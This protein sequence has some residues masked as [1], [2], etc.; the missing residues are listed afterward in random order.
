MKDF[1]FQGSIWLG[2]R[3]ANG[4][5]DRL[6]QVGD[7]P[8]LQL[9]LTTDKSKRTESRSG[10]HVTSAT[11]Q[12]GKTAELSMTLNYF[13]GKQLALGLY[14][15][16]ITVEG[17]TV[18]SEPFPPN[19][20]VGDTI[21]LDHGQISELVITDATTGTP[22]TL[23]PDTDYRVES[24]NG[25]LITL[26]SLGTPAFQQPLAGAYKYAG[27]VDVAMFTAGIPER[28]LLLDGINT[29]DGADYG[30]PVLL[31][32]W[33]CSFD[34]IAQ[35]DFISDDF[36]QLQLSGDVLY[37]DINASNSELGGFGKIS[38]SSE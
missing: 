2:T 30:K 27:G 23:V 3:L 9:K 36:G 4:K 26:S 32:L 18:T 20:K 11:L 25:G 37:D 6:E 17:G 28:Y 15:T 29:V 34:P 22:K 14:G 31:R 24:A 35:V 7:A 5:P 12:K 10:L 16:I 19:L 8:A 13:G 38:L 21:A 1:S 33:R